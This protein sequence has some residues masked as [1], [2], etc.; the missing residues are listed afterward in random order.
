MVM[1]KDNGQPIQQAMQGKGSC[2]QDQRPV[3]P[4]FLFMF[5]KMGCGAGRA[6]MGNVTADQKKE[7]IA[8]KKSDG[9]REDAELF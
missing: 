3:A 8:R 7:G 1:T 5:L 2:Q 9:G 4:M 6:N